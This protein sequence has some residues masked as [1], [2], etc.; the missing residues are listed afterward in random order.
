MRIALVS[1]ILVSGALAGF[2]GC[3]SS[4]SGDTG[5]AGAGGT[6]GMPSIDAGADAPAEATTDAPAEATTDAPAEATID[7]PVEA[8]PSADWSCVGSVTYP[9]PA[10]QTAAL[11]L[12][13]KDFIAKTAIA[14]LTVKACSNAD[15]DC[16]S[17]VD[18]QSSDGGGQVTLTLPTTGAGFDGFLDISDG[19]TAKLEPTVLYFSAPIAANATD[20]VN[21][22][23][24]VEA[25]LLGGAV[26]TID[27]TRG[28]LLASLA[29]C[30]GAGAIGA[31]V[32]VDS[33]DATAKPFFFSMGFPS[34]SATS[35]DDSGY[36][37]Y[38]NLPVG[39]AVVT[40]KDAA[41]GTV[42]GTTSVQVRAD[43]LTILFLAPTPLPTP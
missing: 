31:K 39:P 23:T 11:T 12:Q 38:L 40:G 3:S 9:A 27:H 25:S 43:S 7:A 13:F 24:K 4:D 8:G 29:D 2:V 1:T 41:S 5:A 42:F 14:G 17:P 16:Q 37:G 34:A 6:G 18:T 35:T 21:L 26:G 19:A 22:I 30:A 20:S 15:T 10:G 36:A 28:A 32:E 33:A